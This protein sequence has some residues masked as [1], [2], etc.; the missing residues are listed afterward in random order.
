MDIIRL[1]M[2][3]PDLPP[4]DFIVDALAKAAHRADMHGYTPNGRHGRLSRGDC[5]LLLAPL[6]GRA[7]P[8]N[9]RFGTD[10]IQGRPVQSSQ[11]LLN[12]GDVSLV[13]DPGY[14]VYTGSS[15]IAGAE[16][17]RLPLLE[18]NG[19]MPDLDAI[20]PDVA[21]RAKIL[22]LNYP[23]N[24]TGGI[25]TA[26]FFKKA[27]D[28]GREYN[29]V[30]AHDA[31]YVDVCFDGYVA[32]S[33]MQVPGAKDVAIE[34]N[35]LSKSYNMGGWRLGMAVGNPQVI[36]YL[37]TYKSQMDSPILDRSWPPVKPP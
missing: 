21:R 11:V 16:I 7:K 2:G 14:P 4:A 22:W 35:S 13:P 6:W 31:P 3:S 29:L 9:R 23:N 33:L 17:Y 5:R 25:A 1:D 20:P 32:P 34:F 24:P 28:F 26:G 18:E 19:F 27:V 12:P 10:R 8:T 15:L 36:S 37:H 30:V